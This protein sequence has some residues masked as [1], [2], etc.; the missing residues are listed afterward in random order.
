MF[1]CCIRMILQVFCPELK[2]WPPGQNR[3]KAD[4]GGVIRRG[5]RGVQS[6][7]QSFEHVWGSAGVLFYFVVVILLSANSA[8]DSDVLFRERSVGHKSHGRTYN[9]TGNPR[10]IAL[11]W[12]Y[13]TSSWPMIDGSDCQRNEVGHDEQLETRAAWFDTGLVSRETLWSLMLMFVPANVLQLK[14]MIFK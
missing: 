5:E 8:F 14:V 10:N 13:S 1:T 11:S 9:E 7:E 4:E 3:R 6:F 2:R 12:K